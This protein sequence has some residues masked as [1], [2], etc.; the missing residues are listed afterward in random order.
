[1]TSFNIHK[2]GQVFLGS[3]TEVEKMF[4]GSIK[5]FDST[6][7]LETP[8]VVRSSNMLTITNTDSRSEAIQIYDNN[9]L[10]ATIALP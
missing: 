4:V 6:P 1:M 7:P 5:V 8:T 10:I 2:I 3:T 9:V